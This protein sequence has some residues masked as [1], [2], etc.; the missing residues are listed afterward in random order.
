MYEQSVF[1][2][3]YDIDGNVVHV[4]HNYEL[5]YR[6]NF[7]LCDDG[8]IEVTSS[9]SGRNMMLY[10]IGSEQTVCH[11][12]WKMYFAVWEHRQVMFLKRKSVCVMVEI[13]HVRIFIWGNAYVSKKS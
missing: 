12:W 10:S 5:G 3:F 2:S 4:F 6:T 11:Q 7:D 8:L 13:W 1:Y 9:A